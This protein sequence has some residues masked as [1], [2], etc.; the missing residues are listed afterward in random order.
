MWMP[1]GM[2]L[3]KLYESKNTSEAQPE[4]V[5]ELDSLRQRSLCGRCV[6][7]EESHGRTIEASE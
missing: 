4:P 5:E 3:A 2:V 6:V 7:I 1:T